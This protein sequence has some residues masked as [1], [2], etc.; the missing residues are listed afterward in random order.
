MTTQNLYGLTLRGGGCQTGPRPI[1]PADFLAT[2]DGVD[3]KITLTWDDTDAVYDFG[4]LYYSLDEIEWLYLTKFKPELETFLH[5]NLEPGTAY[6]YRLR[7]KRRFKWSVYATTD[8]ETA[9]E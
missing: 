6:Y 8:D 7:V 4:E 2:A 3:P 1:L 9:A 5:D